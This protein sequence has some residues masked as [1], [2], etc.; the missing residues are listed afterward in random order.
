MTSRREILRLF[1]G[2]AATAAVGPKQAAQALGLERGLVAGSAIPEGDVS[3]EPPDLVGGDQTWRAFQN[4]RSIIWQ[5]RDSE[6]EASLG[7]LPPHI[8]EKKSWSSVFKASVHLREQ[9]ILEAM[10]NEIERDEDARRKFL[11]LLGIPVD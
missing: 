11:G 6:R 7:H 2:G 4:V 3:A 10:M 9:L 5:R 1:A 8:A